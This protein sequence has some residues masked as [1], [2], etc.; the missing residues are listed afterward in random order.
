[1]IKAIIFDPRTKIFALHNLIT[2]YCARD[3]VR[4]KSFWGKYGN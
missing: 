3:L 2:D 1:M 4:G